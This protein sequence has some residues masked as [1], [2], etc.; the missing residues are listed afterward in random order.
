M[1]IKCFDKIPDLAKVFE[2]RLKEG[3]SE[4]E[5]RVE[6]LKAATEYYKNLYN[7]VESFKKEVNPEYIPKKLSLLNRSKE[8]KAIGSEYQAKIDEA[9]K[10]AE[11][12]KPSKV[13]PKEDDGL[14]GITHAKMNETAK[15]FGLDMY[16]ESPEKISEWMEVADKKLQNT[17]N[18]NELFDKLRNG[19]SPDKVET[20]MMIKYMADLK[21]KIRVNPSD[22]LL[23]QLKR[24]KDLFNIAGREQGKSF[25]ARQELVPVKEE[26]ADWLLQK[27]E[28]IDRTNLTKEQKKSVAD[29]FNEYESKDIVV[30]EKTAQFEEERSRVAAEKEFNKI[31]KKRV[32][33]DKLSHDQRVAERKAAVDAAREALK[34]LRTGQS[35]L[36]AVPL[37]GVRELIA[38]APHVKTFVESLV[39]EK[40]EKLKEVVSKAYAEFKDVLDGLTEKHIHDI[41]AGVYN[42]KKYTKNE[43]TLRVKDLSDEAKLINK[44]EDLVSGKELDVKKKPEDRNREI[45]ELKNKIK[46]YREQEAEANKFYTEEESTERRALRT[47]KTKNENERAKLEEKI[48]KGDFEPNAKPNPIVDNAEIKKRNPVLWKET[49]DAIAAKE[50]AKHKWELEKYHD[51]QARRSDTRKFFDNAVKTASTF[52]AIKAGID[53]SSTFVQLGLVWAFNPKAI[54]KAKLKAWGDANLK[55][56][57][58]NL[59]ELHSQPYW[60]VLKEMGIDITEPKS[61][62]EANLEDLYSGNLLDQEFK[63]GKKKINPWT[64]TGGIFE[65]FFTSSGNYTRVNLAL[66]RMAQLEM[67]GKSIETHPEDYKA[68]GRAINELTA[69][70]K[71][72]KYLE[73]ARPIITPFIWAPKMIASAINTM[74]ITDVAYFMIGKKGGYYRS[75]PPAQAEWAMKKMATA[76]GVGFGILLAARAGGLIVSLDPRDTDF[77]EIKIG[78][79]SYNVFGRYA[80]IIKTIAQILMGVRVKNGVG[81]DLDKGGYGATT[82]GDVLF[83]Y[84]RGKL[85]PLSGFGYDLIF[86]AQENYYTHEKITIKSV[87]GSLLIPMSIE[88]LRR[89][90]QQNG[91]MG[92]FTRGVPAFLGVNVSNDLDFPQKPKK[93]GAKSME[94]KDRK[95]KK[96]APDN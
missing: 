55:T 25:R 21:A 31:I 11:V 4:H 61:L 22:E 56:Y 60:P 85:T 3:M 27:Q 35:G 92:I 49:M 41:I 86:N 70:G 73:S 47:I 14:T 64:Y 90:L 82:R 8:I 12:E 72:N 13:A 6:G 45:S 66:Q 65:R 54:A 29:S 26:L 58:R 89:G 2:K 32:S 34:K 69:R 84:V 95:E 62:A 20:I 93:G 81:K 5:Q 71:M 42:E 96:D 75:M 19:Y 63:V 87:P 16:K 52:K 40:A 51:E 1:P 79:N 43:I 48:S 10:A 36:S 18:L 68:A 83:G 59:A 9:N 46:G 17:D 53:D 38:I 28:S 88:D 7:E 94:V 37:P 76:M 67:E 24:A 74:G 50:E 80:G 91:T 44:L 39:S 78:N 77:A 30:K 57:K 33:K 15:E 23:T